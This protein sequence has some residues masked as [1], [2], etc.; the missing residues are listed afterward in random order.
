MIKSRFFE[1]YRYDKKCYQLVID[2]TQLHFFDQEHI[3]RSLTRTREDGSKTYH[4]ISVT[5]YL[6]IEENLM[7]PRASK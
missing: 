3:E 5:A 6:V 2:G 7:I 4:T 1:R